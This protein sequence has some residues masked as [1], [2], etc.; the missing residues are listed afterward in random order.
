MAVRAVALSRPSTGAERTCRHLEQHYRFIT[1][2]NNNLVLFLDFR[3]W[4]K[5]SS[6]ETTQRPTCSSHSATFTPPLSHY[7]GH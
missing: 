6:L 5:H 2:R 7:L 4:S 3:A 1:L